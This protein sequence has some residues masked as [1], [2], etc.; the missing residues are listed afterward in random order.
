MS[1]RIYQ[2]NKKLETPGEHGLPKLP[3]E[4]S[5]VTYRG[6]DGDFNVYRHEKKHDDPDMALLLFPL[7][8]IHKL[9]KEGWPV[10]PGDLGEN[11]TTTGIPYDNF[12]PG[13]I[14]RLGDQTE[15][16]ISRPC[17]A[18]QNLYLL[19][20][21]GQERGPTFLKTLT[22]KENGVIKN[23]RGWYAIVL[24]EGPIR[25]EDSIEEIN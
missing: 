7:E 8:M 4:S 16:Q 3:V 11:I 1:G 2:I 25:K 14:Y 24:K 12:A 13:K 22:W 5:L 17:T 15:I 9:N 20:Y 6:I 18:C 10:S 21:V 23:R 19:P